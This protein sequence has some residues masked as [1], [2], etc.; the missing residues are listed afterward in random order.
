MLAGTLLAAAGMFSQAI[1]HDR[2]D[3]VLIATALVGFGVGLVFACL[4]MLI[5]AAV[6][7]QSTGV[8]SGMNANLRTL[9]GAIGTAVM[10]SIVAA[11]TTAGLAQEI[12]YSRGFAVLGVLFV[13]A[14]G[15][16]LAIPA[17][18]GEELEDRLDA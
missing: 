5:V 11:H 12:G 13:A 16:A 2:I 14:A 9:G 17:I 18:T 7:P 4:A 3:Q 8:A 10:T 1:F 6:P 15:A